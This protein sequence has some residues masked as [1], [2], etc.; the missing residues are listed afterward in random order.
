[1]KWFKKIFGWTCFEC[2]KRKI[3]NDIRHA[4]GGYE[5]SNFYVCDSCKSNWM[6]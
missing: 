1:M 5:G 4:I 2:G 6:V 3:K